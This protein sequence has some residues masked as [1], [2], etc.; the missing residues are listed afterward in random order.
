MRGNYVELYNSRMREF[1][2]FKHYDPIRKRWVGARYL[3]EREVI[4]ERYEKWEITGPPELRPEGPAISPT[5][6][7]NPYGLP[8]DE[9]I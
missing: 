5:T 3:A 4:M 8:T 2:P 9:R 6:P 1:F 7:E